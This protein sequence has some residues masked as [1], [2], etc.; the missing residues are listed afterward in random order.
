M[1]CHLTYHQTALSYGVESFRNHSG[2]ERSKILTGHRIIITAPGS[3]SYAFAFEQTI[4][5]SISRNRRRKD[6]TFGQR[7]LLRETE[8]CKIQNGNRLSDSVHGDSDVVSM[9]DTQAKVSCFETS[10]AKSRQKPIVTK[11]NDD[12]ALYVILLWY[13]TV[14]F[15]LDDKTTASH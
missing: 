11:M 14:P 4:L 5:A 3:R 15:L 2:I 1:K 12:F 9:A 8:E 13:R 6:H 10:H 7:S